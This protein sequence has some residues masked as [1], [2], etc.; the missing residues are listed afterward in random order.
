MNRIKN[1]SRELLC[2]V[3]FIIC[4][5]LPLFAQLPDIFRLEY[6]FIP[7]SKSDDEY[8]RFKFALNYPFKLKNDSYIIVGGEYN[9]I[10]L[11]LEDDYDFDTSLIDALHIIDFN[12]SYISNLNDH[13]K[14]GINFNPRIA[15][16]LTQSITKDDFFINGG[17]F[18][19]RDRR[20]LESGK[21]SGR[22]IIGLTY[23]ATTGIPLPLPFV[24]Y[25]NEFNA[26]WSYNLG[27][28]RSDLSYQLSPKQ[29]LQL[30]TALDG[31]Y[32][33]VQNSV[34]V[35][36]RIADNI[37]LSL[38]VGGLGYKYAFT[39]HLVAYTY[40][41]F[42]FKLNNVL[43]NEDRS[44]IFKLDDLNAFYLRSGIKFKI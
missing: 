2:C 5:S 3:F 14:F 26:D 37:S 12:T 23:N 44:E 13:W 21:T 6:S 32:A 29:K 31:Y 4:S 36:D 15:S 7:K 8:S 10:R 39:D 25:S 38:V 16:T 20:I 27:I 18:F 42:T 35:G 1:K 33:N 22:L 28:P 34:L 43:R 11:E 24:S 17:V 41:G 19:V 40:T 30:F 9:L